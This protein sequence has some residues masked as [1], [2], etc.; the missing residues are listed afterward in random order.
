M[1]R[2]I[3]R[4]ND[5]W[6]HW[7]EYYRDL[8]KKLIIDEREYG[9]DYEKSRSSKLAWIRCSPSKDIGKVML[10]KRYYTDQWKPMNNPSWWVKQTTHVPRRRK[11]RDLNRKVLHLIDLED[12]PLYPDRGRVPYYW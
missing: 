9:W 5:N 12:C 3:R 6:S 4:K 1:S 10:C 7:Y 11:E 8:E 2:T